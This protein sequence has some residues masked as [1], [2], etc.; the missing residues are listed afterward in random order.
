MNENFTCTKART[1]SVSVERCWQTCVAGACCSGLAECGRCQ[2]PVI[3]SDC[4]LSVAPPRL[5]TCSHASGGG[6][7]D[8]VLHY[9]FSR[10]PRQVLEEAAAGHRVCQ[11]LQG[12][13]C[14]LSCLGRNL[15]F[16]VHLQE[17][18]MHR[19][20]QRIEFAKHCKVCKLS[21]L[22]WSD[23]HI[24]AARVLC[25]DPF[26][27]SDTSKHI[28]HLTDTY[29]RATPAGA[30]GPCHRAGGQPRRHAVR[31]HQHGP[32]SQGEL[33]WPAT[34]ERLG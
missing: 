10:R 2:G 29:A 19:Q 14:V 22:Y 6:S 17:A 1:G 27:R 20:P 30:P 8:R 12:T 33:V 31:I 23:G 5:P 34:A 16:F 15:C 25:L 13:C 32:D 7:P 26:V 24:S 21:C 3:K 18:C 4:A 28:V 11:A 9:R